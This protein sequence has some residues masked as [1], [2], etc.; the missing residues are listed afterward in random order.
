[1]TARIGCLGALALWA[2]LGIAIKL[3]GRYNNSDGGGP[4]AVLGL[5]GVA[6]FV[7]ASVFDS[8]AAW[9]RR[10]QASREGE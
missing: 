7:V 3:T 6:L 10:R 2:L 1:M 5:L 4:F 8:L 9:A